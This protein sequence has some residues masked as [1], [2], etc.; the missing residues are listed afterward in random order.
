MKMSR[1]AISL[2]ALNKTLNRVEHKLQN[3]KAQFTVLDSSIQKL[4]ENF[5]CQSTT[6]EN[7]M[8]QNEIWISLLEDR[9]TSVEINLFYSYICETIHYLHSQVLEKLPDLVRALPTLSS[10]LRKKGKNQR[11]RLAW[12]SVLEMLGLQE[13]NVKA[14]CAFF[15]AHSSDACYYPINQRQNYSTNISSI[16]MKVVKNQLLQHSLLSAVHVVEHGK[17]W[18]AFLDQKAL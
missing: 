1:E 8:D 16:I 11:I 9:F 15:I 4:S 13:G 2:C 3:I 10:V 7:Q 14:L 17:A 5:E 6:L 12:E 18:E